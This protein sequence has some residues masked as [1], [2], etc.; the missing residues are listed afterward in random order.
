MFGAHREAV[1]LVD[2][3]HRQGL[4]TDALFRRL[5]LEAVAGLFSVFGLGSGLRLFAPR[6]FAELLS[7]RR[8]RGLYLALGPLAQRASRDVGPN[9]VS[10]GESIEITAQEVSVYISS[11]Q[12]PSCG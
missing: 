1:P 7:C 10:R 5:R 4:E 8:K 6:Q 11:Q 12:S 2:E 9:D 3:I